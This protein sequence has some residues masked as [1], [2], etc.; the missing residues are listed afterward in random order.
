MRNSK[1]QSERAKA[2]WSILRDALLQSQTSKKKKGSTRTRTELGV[3]NNEDVDLDLDAKGKGKGRGINKHSIHKFPGFQMLKRRTVQKNAADMDEEH[4][5]LEYEIPMGHIHIGTRRQPNVNMNVN[6]NMNMNVNMN[7]NMNGDDND[8]GDGVNGYNKNSYPKYL[9]LRTKERKI[10]QTKLTLEELTSHVHY[11]VDNTGNTRV[12]DSSN[13]LAFL[14]MGDKAVPVTSTSASA[15]ASAST[16]E[17]NNEDDRIL[18]GLVCSTKPPFIGIKD[19]L[20]LSTIK[21]AEESIERKTLRVLELGSGM[22]ALPSLALSMINSS[23]NINTNTHTNAGQLD[24][25]EASCNMTQVWQD[26]HIYIDATITDGHPKA[27]QNNMA[28][29]KMNMNMK[30]N[31][32]MDTNLTNETNIHL[33]TNTNTNTINNACIRC[34]PLLWKA[35]KDGAKECID[36]MRN[37][38]TNKNAEDSSTATTMNTTQTPTPPIPIPIPY[39]LVLV[40]D[41]THFTEFHAD[42]AVTIGRVLRVGG[43]CI[44]CQPRRGTSLGLFMELIHSINNNKNANKN[45]SYI[46]IHGEDKASHHEDNEN[47]NKN[48]IQSP[49]FEMDLH[50]DYNREI[51][52]L[53]QSFLQDEDETNTNTKTNNY[54]PNIHYPLLLILKKKRDF[55]EDI[56]TSRALGHIKNR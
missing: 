19:M 20:S 44:L 21:S 16:I 36:L 5:I 33:Q 49:L 12:W 11:G 3:P 9:L 56:D 55:Q 37:T 47:E 27:V 24:T 54:E 48:D 10:F 29:V 28:C 6:M 45:N 17:R 8:D 32:Q 41:C 1:D 15:S 42:L 22:A 7:M 18:G 25:D 31:M 34:C 35:N 50:K 43:V 38:N 46:N 23:T 39:D 30:M 52:Q 2:R 53:H 40:S 14:V 13:V 4:E 51:S 26:E